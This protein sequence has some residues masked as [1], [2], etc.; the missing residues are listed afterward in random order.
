MHGYTR[1]LCSCTVPSAIVGRSYVA[2]LS[3]GRSRV[4]GLVGRAGVVLD[5]GKGVPPSG[6]EG[7]VL[8]GSTLLAGGVIAMLMFLP[9]SIGS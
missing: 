7:L 4:L 2:C 8:L 3:I 1:R 5:M 6:V 9:R